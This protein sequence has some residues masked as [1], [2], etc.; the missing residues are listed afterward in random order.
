[1]RT[2]I[3][4][5]VGYIATTPFDISFNYNTYYITLEGECTINLPQIT[6]EDDGFYI[7]FR[8]VYD[9]Y[10]LIT[11]QSNPTTN[12]IVGPSTYLSY[13]VSDYSCRLVDGDT[14]RTFRVGTVA[15][16]TYWFM[17]TT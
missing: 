5:N 15:G 7:H 13:I 11:F 8:R 12:N 4:E 14:N 10:G 1:M 17:T 2:A 16:T 3:K 9:D 6:S